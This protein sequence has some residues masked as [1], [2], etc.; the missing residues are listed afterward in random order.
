[1]FQNMNMNMKNYNKIDMDT[2]NQR[3]LWNFSKSVDGILHKIHGILSSSVEH[4]EY[5]EEKVI[6]EIRCRR[7]TFHVAELT[8]MQV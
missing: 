4:T 7:T 3:I 1:M 8:K 5:K 2:K 6:M